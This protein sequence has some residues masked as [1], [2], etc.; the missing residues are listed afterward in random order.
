MQHEEDQR[1]DEDQVDQSAGDVD[2]ESEDPKSDQDEADDCEHKNKA[3]CLGIAPA[4][5]VACNECL[6]AWVFHQT[7]LTRARS[8]RNESEV[9]KTIHLVPLL[10]ALLLTSAFA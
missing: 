5:S 2:D 9:M 10:S 8:W 7:P 3:F 4:P 1:Q 6:S